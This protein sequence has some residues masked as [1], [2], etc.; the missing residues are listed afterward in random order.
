MILKRVKDQTLR[1]LFA[2]T[3]FGKETWPP[4]MAAR[5]GRPESSSGAAPRKAGPLP[6][7]QV[8][9]QVGEVGRRRRPTSTILKQDE[10]GLTKG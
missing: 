6:M 1:G 4:G 7:R 8:A 10:D 2:M 5:D 3:G 9:A